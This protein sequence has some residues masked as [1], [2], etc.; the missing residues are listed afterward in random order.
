MVWIMSCVDS[1][2]I[3]IYKGLPQPL[4][5]VDTEPV[6]S[7]GQ[8]QRRRRRRSKRQVERRFENVI[9]FKQ[10][11]L[12][13]CIM[14]RVCVCWCKPLWCLHLNRFPS[15]AS[16]PYWVFR[17]CTRIYVCPSSSSSSMWN[18]CEEDARPHKCCSYA[19]YSPE[20]P[21]VVPWSCR[22]TH[23]YTN[24]QRFWKRDRSFSSTKTQKTLKQ[25]T[26]KNAIERNG[27]KVDAARRGNKKQHTHTH[28]RCAVINL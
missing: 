9:P 5:Q 1:E 12:A 8:R 24:T 7:S 6:A 2:R 22:G 4:P 21:C 15:S 19:H 27:K 16:S 25:T 23:T 18:L 28:T 13:H 26:T 14:Q 20:V 3:H 10:T 11:S 17:G